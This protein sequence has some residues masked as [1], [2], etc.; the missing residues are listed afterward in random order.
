MS[1]VVICSEVDRNGRD[2]IIAVHGP[3]TGDDAKRAAY[4]WAGGRPYG[5]GASH[6]PLQLL[7]PDDV[8]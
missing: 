5:D 4:L 2:Y 8:E 3:F 6:E 1:Y 7:A